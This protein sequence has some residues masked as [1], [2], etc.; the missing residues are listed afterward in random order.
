MFEVVGDYITDARTLL[1]DEVEPYR[2]ETLDLV[3]A[4]NLVLFDVR[5]LRP[6]LMVDYL[7][8]VPQYDWNDSSSTTTGVD[9]TNPTWNNWV[10][11][12]QA[13]RK[14]LVYGIV[15]HAMSRDQEDI[16]DDRANANM[17]TFENILTGVIET[18]GKQPPKG[19]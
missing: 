5:R 13:F 12:E 4:L 18:K 10:P 3:N 15:A 16:D 8:S 9:S 11:M 14:A 7:D 2:Y 6:D 1:Q 19:P 17:K